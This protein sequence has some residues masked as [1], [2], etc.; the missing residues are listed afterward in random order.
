M[1]LSGATGIQ[2]AKAMRSVSTTDARTSLAFA[3]ATEIVRS[4]R[5]VLREDVGKS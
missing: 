4:M 3:P 5:Y 2:I 1:T